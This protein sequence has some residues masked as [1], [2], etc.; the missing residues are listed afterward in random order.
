MVSTISIG[1]GSVGVSARPAFPTASS[2][3]GK[4]SIS[5]LRALRS[6]ATWV[7]EARGTVTGMSRMDPSSRGG[8]NSRPMGSVLKATKE[9]ASVIPRAI[10]RVASVL[11]SAALSAARKARTAVTIGIPR[12][13][14][15][16]RK[17]A[18]MKKTTGPGC[19]ISQ[20][21][22]GS[23]T[24]MKERT[25]QFSRSSFMRP[26]ITRGM[27]AGSSVMVRKRAATRAKVFVKAR[28]WNIFPSIP[29]SAKTGRKESSM[30]R[31]EK[32]RGRP[33]SFRAGSR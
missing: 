32:K 30:M 15:A 12:N 11:M 27:R 14:L 10:P 17:S 8:M 16:R 4:E 31:T 20:R 18:A 13:P 21:R 9:T 24:L 28:G 26:R 5:R 23:Y 29:P 3:S 1:E 22:M 33:T 7:I 19:G 2:T 6:S 25:S